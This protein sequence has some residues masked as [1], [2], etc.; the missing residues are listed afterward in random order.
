MMKQTSKSCLI[1]LHSKFSLL[2]LLMARKVFLLVV[3]MSSAKGQIIACYHQIMKKLIP[4]RIVLHL[5][6][7]L[8]NGFS[9]CLVWT[10][11]TD[12]IVVI[13]G[14]LHHLLTLNPSARIWI[15]F[16]TGKAFKYLNINSISHAIGHDKSLAL[17]I[18]HSLLAVILRQVSLAR[19]RCQLGRLGNAIQKSPM[20]LYT[21]HLIPL[22]L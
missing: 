5:V 15:A 13:L 8:T 1:S 7:S 22:C 16:G 2:I 20:L 4:C 11:D 21:W 10:V 18:F 9:T 14:Q 3:P 12:I 6:D 19:G 17:P